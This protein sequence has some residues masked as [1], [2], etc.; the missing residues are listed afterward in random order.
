MEEAV[1]ADLVLHV[2]DVSHPQYEDQRA[3][4]EEVLGDLG[5]ARDR[6]IEVYNKTDRADAVHIRRRVALTL[7][8]LTGCGVDRL[9]VAIRDRELRGGEVMQLEF[10]HH[11]SRLLAKLH[12]V[13]EVH[14]QQITDH[15]VRIT[16]W[17]PQSSIHL[18]ENFSITNSLKSVKV[19]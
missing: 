14:E 19:S 6:V 1:A 10:P 11:E 17:V 3:I 8:A 4:G 2:I 12:D 7:S 16:A 5:V 9:I 13:S 18:F 15:V